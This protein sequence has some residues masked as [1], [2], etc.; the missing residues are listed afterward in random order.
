MKDAL[1][2]LLDQLIQLKGRNG[3]LESIL[4]MA[5]HVVEQA[6]ICDKHLGGKISDPLR[7]GINK[8]EAALIAA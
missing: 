5:N 2:P 8:L 3:Q 1:K 4:N 6:R 7:D